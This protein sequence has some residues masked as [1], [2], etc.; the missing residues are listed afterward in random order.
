MSFEVEQEKSGLASHKNYPAC[1]L[2]FPSIFKSKSNFPS[3]IVLDKLD[4]DVFMPY[5][6]V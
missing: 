5:L 1:K 4:Y 2:F 3:K 6:R